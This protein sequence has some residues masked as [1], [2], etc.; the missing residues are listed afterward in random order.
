MVPGQAS[1]RRAG[2]PVAARGQDGGGWGGVIRG[3]PLTEAAEDGS[4]AKR[5][6][7][8]GHELGR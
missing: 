4:S 1:R 5:D 8:V 7:H 2:G 3:R 6:F